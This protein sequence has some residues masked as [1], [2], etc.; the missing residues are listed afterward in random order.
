PRF[1]D[2]LRTAESRQ[3]RQGFAARRRRPGAIEHRAESDEVLLV[4]EG[5]RLER[6]LLRQAQPLE[7]PPKETDV[8]PA[9][10]TL[11]RAAGGAGIDREGDDLGIGL[12]RVRPDQ[13]T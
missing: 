7:H 8:A 11:P 2:R 13:L 9:D 3:G 5:A 12:E 1:P 6:S 4:Q 10:R